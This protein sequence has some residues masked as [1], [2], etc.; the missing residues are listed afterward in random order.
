[1]HCTE[2]IFDFFCS[3]PSW[4]WE[5]SALRATRWSSRSRRWSRPTCTRT[6]SWWRPRTSPSSATPWWSGEENASSQQVRFRVEK[7]GTT[8]IA[9]TTK[10]FYCTYCKFTVHTTNLLYIQQIYCTYCKFTLHT[11]NSLYIL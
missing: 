10:Q 4:W 6:G 5:P 2:L 3:R 9:N 11:L 1:M 7:N 8:S